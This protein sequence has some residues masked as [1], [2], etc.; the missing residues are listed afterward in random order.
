V[1][2]VESFSK[3]QN[4]VVQRRSGG[5]QGVRWLIRCNGLAPADAAAANQ[6]D[7]IKL[8]RRDILSHLQAAEIIIELA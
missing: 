6:L 2:I 5:N 3:G 4:R 8:S 7:V 1:L